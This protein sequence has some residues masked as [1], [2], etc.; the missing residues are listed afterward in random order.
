MTWFIGICCSD[1]GLPSLNS[2]PNQGEGTAR[3]SRP[4]SRNQRMPSGPGSRRIIMPKSTQPPLGHEVLII[5]VATTSALVSLQRQR[6]DCTPRSGWP[7]IDNGA[8]R[9]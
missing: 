2:N 3:S 8:P 9:R 5:R 7:E 6:R 1:V 4:R